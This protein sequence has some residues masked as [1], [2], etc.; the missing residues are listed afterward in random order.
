[1]KFFNID[2]HA[3][4]IEDIKYIFN[5]LG[6]EVT[7]WSLSGHAHIMGKEQKKINLND[8]TILEGCPW[9][10][11]ENA[12]VF[13]ET[14]KKE[15]S[16]YDGFICCYPVEL[17]I[18]YELWEKP[19]IIVN[20]IRY[21][22]PY[23]LMEKNWNEL[24][25]VLLSLNKKNLLYYV[26][27]NKGDQYYSKYFLN[28]DPIWIPSLCEYT[29]SKYNRKINEFLIS[30]RSYVKNVSYDIAKPINSVGHPYTWK[31]TYSYNGFIFVPYHNGCMTIYECYTANVP[32]FF[33]SK[34]FG[35]KL[36]KEG[37]MFQDLT[38]YKIYN[39]PEPV[40]LDNP[41]NLSNEKN[42][43]M[44]FDTCDFYDDENMPHCIYFDSYEDLNNKLQLITGDELDNISLKMK[45][46]NKIRKNM[47]YNKW[48]KILDSIKSIKI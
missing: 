36:L 24:N 28:I 4:V 8:G 26:S 11:R 44:W 6:H 3:S 47:V 46:Y 23:T 12:K 25:D 17:C 16:I 19:I 31:D 48:S 15:L 41:N 14:Y 32:M 34:D 2:V 39:K 1:M 33:P 7:D 22:H 38:F 43:N 29:N 27:N 30:N 5:N 10:T 18:L 35:K 21:E 42:I 13:Y 40:E 9:V 45:E 37:K 20:C